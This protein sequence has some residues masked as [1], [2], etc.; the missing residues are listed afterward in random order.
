MAYCDV[1]NDRQ[2]QREK[3]KPLKSGSTLTLVCEFTQV[4]ICLDFE[5]VLWAQAHG[6][7]WVKNSHCKQNNC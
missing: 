5:G 7:Q 1:S 2:I 6:C 3:G 4:A